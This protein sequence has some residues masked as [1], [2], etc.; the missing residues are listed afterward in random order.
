MKKKAITRLNNLEPKR[1]ETFIEFPEK[2]MPAHEIKHFIR[3]LKTETFYKRMEG[4]RRVVLH[5][6]R[7]ERAFAFLAAAQEGFAQAKY[8]GRLCNW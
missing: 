3:V 2:G 6:A 1:F 8:I 5:F 7:K 4:E